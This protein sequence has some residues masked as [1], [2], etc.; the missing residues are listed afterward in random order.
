MTEEEL[1]K[2]NHKEMLELLSKR[3][4]KHDNLAQTSKELQQSDDE[5]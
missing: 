1:K 2:L 3:F 4:E 5:S